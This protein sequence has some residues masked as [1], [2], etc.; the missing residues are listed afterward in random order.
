ME[1]SMQVNFNIPVLGFKNE[2][3]KEPDGTPALIKNAVINSLAAEERIDGSEKVRR[4]TLAMKVSA[5]EQSY[6]LE[7]L[8]LIKDVVGKFMPPLVCGRVF[9]L[10]DRV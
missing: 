4:F 2:Q 3:L 1:Q 5:D 9:E 7:E 10:I 6:L 8:T